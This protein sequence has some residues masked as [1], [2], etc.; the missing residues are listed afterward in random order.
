MEEVGCQLHRK[1]PCTSL[2]ENVRVHSKIIQ[3]RGMRHY[4]IY[5]EIEKILYLISPFGQKKLAEYMH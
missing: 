5:S 3:Q 1:L 2:P 4:P